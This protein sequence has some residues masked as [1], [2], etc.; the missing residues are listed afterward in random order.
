[1]K[2]LGNLYSVRC[3]EAQP[4]LMEPTFWFP[5][6]IM[7][8]KPLLKYKIGLSLQ[9][10]E[11]DFHLNVSRRLTVVMCLTQWYLSVGKVACKMLD[12]LTKTAVMSLL[13]DL[14]IRMLPS[15]YDCCPDYTRIPFVANFFSCCHREYWCNSLLSY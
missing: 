11:F 12:K 10:S 2:S 14:H 7:L 8:R 1:V 3:I 5:V 15:Q 6:A 4:P 13:W 9:R